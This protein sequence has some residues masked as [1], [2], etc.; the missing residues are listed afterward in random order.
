[1]AQQEQTGSTYWDYNAKQY[2]KTMK[3]RYDAKSQ[4]NRKFLENL[5]D[6]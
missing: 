3:E 4:A 6:T 1:M 5:D 2:G